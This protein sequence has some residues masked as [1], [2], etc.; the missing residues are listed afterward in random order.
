MGVG[1]GLGV[2]LANHDTLMNNGQTASVHGETVVVELKRGGQTHKT[3]F[4]LT[5][6]VVA[7]SA[8]QCNPR[9]IQSWH[10]RVDRLPDLALKSRLAPAGRGRERSIWCPAVLGQGVWRP[11]PSAGWASKSHRSYSGEHPGLC[12]EEQTPHT[13]HDITKHII[14]IKVHT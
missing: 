9:Q 13:C 6:C 10:T 7:L 2:T 11:F 4:T 8:S 5:T 3:G 1:N 12:M 14:I